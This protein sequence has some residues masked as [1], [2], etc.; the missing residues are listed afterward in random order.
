MWP[1]KTKYDYYKIVSNHYYGLCGVTIDYFR[2]KESFGIKKMFNELMLSK[3]GY[4]PITK[5]EYDRK[6]TC[7]NR[8]S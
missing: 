6:N 1:F 4:H 7:N 5:D 3:L 8:G 2:V